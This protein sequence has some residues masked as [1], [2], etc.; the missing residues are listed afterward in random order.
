MPDNPISASEPPPPP[1]PRHQRRWIKI[2]IG[3]PLAVIILAGTL[4]IFLRLVTFHEITNN[5]VN[6][7]MAPMGQI[8]GLKGSWPFH[9]A[10]D[11]LTLY[12]TH[13]PWLG[14]WGIQLEWSPSGL[15][16]GQLQTPRLSIQRLILHRLPKEDP[17]LASATTFSPWPWVIHHLNVE[18]VILGQALVAEEARFTLNGHLQDSPTGDFH[19]KGLLDRQDKS[20]ATAALEVV[21]SRPS[22]NLGVHFSLE[23]RSGLLSTWMGTA[24]DAPWLAKLEG[25]A[26]WNNWQGQLSL[27]GPVF[28]QVATTLKITNE[29]RL[30]LDGTWS[31]PTPLPDAN[32]V[33]D[34]KIPFG[35]TALLDPKMTTLTFSRLAASIPGLTLDGQGELQMDGSNIAG[36]IQLKAPSLTPFSPLAKIPLSGPF[37]LTATLSGSAKAPEWTFDSESTRLTLGD[38]HLDHLQAHLHHKPSPNNLD[39]Q[40]FSLTGS[41][42]R[43]QWTGPANDI[44]VN[45]PQLSI[46][47]ALENDQTWRARKV[48]IKDAHGQEVTASAVWIP[49]TRMATID[50]WGDRFDLSTLPLPVNHRLSG[51]VAFS[52]IADL[53]TENKRLDFRLRTQGKQW[54]G[55]PK[56]IAPLLGNRPRLVVGGWFEPGQQLSIHTAHLQGTA[57]KGSGRA[58]FD[59]GEKNFTSSLQANITNLSSFSPTPDKKITGRMQLKAKS[60]GS[61]NDPWL[62]FEL[63]GNPINLP[64]LTIESADMSFRGKNMLSAPKGQ[65]QSHLNSKKE[66]LTLEGQ[67]QLSDGGQSIQLENLIVSAP[68]SKITGHLKTSLTQFSPQGHLTATIASLAALKP[69]HGQELA[70]KV[71]M[72]L[73]LAKGRGRGLLSTSQLEGPFGVLRDGEI[74][75]DAPV[76]GHH[77]SITAQMVLRELKSPGILLKGLEIHG[78]GDPKQFNFSIAGKGHAKQN[79]SIDARGE[80]QRSGNDIRLQWTRLEGQLHRE[81]YRLQKPWIFTM[82][83]DRLSVADLDLTLA[84]THLSGSLERRQGRLDGQYRIQGNLALLHRLGLLP[85]KGDATLTASMTGTDVNPELVVTVRAQ[86]VNYQG[87]KL[88]QLPP[89]G[90]LG[91]MRIENVQNAKVDFSVSGLGQTPVNITG[92]IPLRLKFSPFTAQLPTKDPLNLHLEAV[93]NLADLAIWSGL[94]EEQHLQGELQ[95]SLQATG[96]FEQPRLEGTLEMKKGSYENTDWGT[97]L[98]DI[99]LQARAMGDRVT[100]DRISLSDGK[101]GWIQAQGQWI[102][103]RKES[104]PFRM[105]TELNKATVLR[106]EDAKATLSGQLIVEG[107][108]DALDIGGTLT[109]NQAEYQL[110]DFSGEPELR[111][112]GIKETDQTLR[113]GIS[114]AK[115]EIS[116]LNLQIAFPGQAF[117]R[118]QGL[119]SQWQGN[120]HVQGD[121]MEPRIEG[122]LEMQ[123][124]YLN[125]LNRRYELTKG[126]IH[127]PG[128]YPPNPTMDVD[129]VTRNQNLEVTAHLEGSASHP[130]LTFSSFPQLPEDEI[131]AKLLFGR[132]T[133]TITP[134]QAIKLATMAEALHRGGPGIVDGIGQKLGIDQLDFKGDSVETGAINAGKYLSDDIY[135][136]VQKGIK[137]DSD[138]INVEY[139]LSPEISLQTG[140]DA[141]SNADVGILWKRDY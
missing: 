137:A 29:Q 24:P 80:L 140:V 57:L 43:I 15:L 36:T 112:V 122:Q 70:G 79:F 138:R 16:L 51:P 37:H 99:Q 8:T 77:G 141:K 129:A 27:T 22:G 128:P 25:T 108:V 6:R 83:K 53:K 115:D 7:F 5:M 46:D 52:G 97:S 106:R 93:V 124:G 120:L 119:E 41:A 131:L 17:S 23:D 63:H 30:D 55:L 13:G 33:P 73:D 116:R 19:F 110:R 113:P 45:Q 98:K 35:L 2:A 126:I 95:A 82:A 28:G 105:T 68:Q 103:D 84:E 12:D 109:V 60:G 62:E 139:N 69:W 81:R 1:R 9:V 38:T 3:V 56:T 136:E 64:P 107:S 21:F 61:W 40:E 100:F 71:D 132:A 4:L 111:V 123:R 75:I 121:L 76:D 54:Q 67:M 118:G 134:A 26:P 104:F 96:N 58:S 89:L 135:L 78:H 50:F 94:G 66:R 114:P 48:H 59:L 130:R 117:I 90:V 74:H 127:F 85:V 92:D 88:S 91:H 11:Q 65:F 87:S 102:L 14:V 47:L 42:S 10:M 125:F 86:N 133:D 39:P 32:I 34:G 18:T 31:L 72:D 44:T 20:H 49:T 101:S